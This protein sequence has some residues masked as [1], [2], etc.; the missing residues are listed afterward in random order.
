MYECRNLDTGEMMAVKQMSFQEKDTGTLQ[1]ICDEIGN[2][3]KVSH[4]NIVQFH[5]LEVYHVS[6]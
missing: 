5:G 1:G 4:E 2:F 6:T 3:Q